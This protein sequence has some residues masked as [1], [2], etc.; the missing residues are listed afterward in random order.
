M[1]DAAIEILRHNNPHDMRGG[2]LVFIERA[3]NVSLLQRDGKH[4][5]YYED[6]LA[7]KQGTTKGDSYL[8]HDL[9]TYN[10]DD[11]HIYFCICSDARRSN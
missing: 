1:I 5:A 11:K 8:S 10:T 7:G 2:Q 3:I 9:V 6:A 4:E